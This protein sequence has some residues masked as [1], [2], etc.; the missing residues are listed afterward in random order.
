MR[1][2]LH[3]NLPEFQALRNTHSTLALFYAGRMLLWYFSLCST[4]FLFDN[5]TEN[6]GGAETR[7]GQSSQTS[8]CFVSCTTRSPKL[9]TWVNMLFLGV[10]E[11]RVECMPQ[12]ASNGCYVVEY[13][14]IG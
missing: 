14:H 4:L 1:A 8:K 5:H 7:Q 9:L 2:W 12:P 13:T 3:Y 10:Y 6:K 11:S